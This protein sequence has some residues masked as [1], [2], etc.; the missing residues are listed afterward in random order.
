MSLRGRLIIDRIRRFIG[1]NYRMPVPPFGDQGYWEKVYAQMG[2]DDWFEWGE[3]AL[4]TDLLEYR[5]R[6][7]GEK[8]NGVELSSSAATAAAASYIQTTWDETIGIPRHD[9]FDKPILMV[10]CGVSKMGEQLVDCGW[11]GPVVQVDICARLLDA[12][13]QRCVD[14]MQN[15]DMSFVQD[16]VNMLSAFENASFHAAIDKGL[17]DSFFSAYEFEQMQSTLHSVH[18]V[19]RPGGI[20]CT[21][22]FSRPRF[23]LDKIY[24]QPKLPWQ[25]VQVRQLD[26]IYL[27]RFQKDTKEERSY[28]RKPKGHHSHRKF[29]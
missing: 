11:R 6:L 21:F 8:K 4:P 26:K 1:E 12:L 10:G 13:S 3:V 14:Y 9:K 29:P 25:N 17:L 24:Y 2:K 19:L 5:Y 18:R 7:M 28:G 16:D 23:L 22:S 15:G 27:Y 20:F